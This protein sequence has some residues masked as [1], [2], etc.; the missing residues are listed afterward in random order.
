MGAF[1]TLQGTAGSHTPFD[2]CQAV[3][4]IIYIK[5]G[6][7]W[8]DGDVY[9]YIYYDIYDTS[10]SMIEMCTYEIYFFKKMLYKI[11]HDA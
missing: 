9:I 3:M 10:T 8:W 1:N 6:K 2:E 7:V 4:I 11:I 5:K